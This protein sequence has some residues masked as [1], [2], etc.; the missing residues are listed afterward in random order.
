[1]GHLNKCL[2]VTGVTMSEINENH[3]VA[4]QSGKWGEQGVPHKGWQCV[5]TQDL[6][7]DREGWQKCEMCKAMD[8]RYVHVMRHPNYPGELGCGCV[9]AGNMEQDLQAAR[10]RESSMKTSLRRRQAFVRSRHW[11]I[12]QK[13]NP[14]MQ[15]DGWTVT[16]FPRGTGFK[17]VLSRADKKMFLPQVFATPNEAKLAAY[18]VMHASDAA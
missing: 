4:R 11:R 7:P 17:A 8:I 18:D 10:H 13:G 9:C 1:M 14:W 15:R 3:A 2:S 16:I 5:D 12:S 6:G